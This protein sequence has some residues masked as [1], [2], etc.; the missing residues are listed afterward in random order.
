MSTI[1]WTQIYKKYKGKW[2]ALARDEKA[3][4]ANGESALEVQNKAKKKIK[5]PILF[6]VPSKILPYVGSY[7]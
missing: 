1:D 3:V 7:V 4:L 5:A 2:V 6:R